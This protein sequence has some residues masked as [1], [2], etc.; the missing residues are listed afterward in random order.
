VLRLVLHSRQIPSRGQD[1][2]G[3]FQEVFW[4]ELLIQGGDNPLCVPPVP[5]GRPESLTFRKPQRTQVGDLCQ[6]FHLEGAKRLHYPSLA[7]GL[8]LLG[9]C[10][11]AFQY[12]SAT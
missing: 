11:D 7:R 2:N 6:V 12:S 5:G 9:T 3:T 10:F 1:P 8:H 4:P